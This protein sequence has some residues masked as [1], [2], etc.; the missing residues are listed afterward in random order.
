[1]DIRDIE[2]P[3]ALAMLRRHVPEA[4]MNIIEAAVEGNARCDKCCQGSV[5]RDKSMK[6]PERE[7]WCLCRGR[8]M[9]LD[10]FCKRWQPRDKPC[11]ECGGDGLIPKDRYSPISTSLTEGY[12]TCPACN[13][14]G[15]SAR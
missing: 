8:V 7:V 15:R 10:D 9:E 2:I 13:G 3:W 12:D 14:T 11:P 1:M 4:I 5:I 6:P